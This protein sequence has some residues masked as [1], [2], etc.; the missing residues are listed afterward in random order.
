MEVGEVSTV[1]VEEAGTGVKVGLTGQ[2]SHQGQ[3]IISWLT[4]TW[5]YSHF[6]TNR[7]LRWYP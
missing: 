2:E 4:Q 1:A 7:N 5:R 6:A 3:F